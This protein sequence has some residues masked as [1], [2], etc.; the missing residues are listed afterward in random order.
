MG[1]S[2]RHGRWLMGWLLLTGCEPAPQ[3]ARHTVEEYRVARDLRES[4]LRSCAD[5][6]GTLRDTPDCVNAQRAAT[7]ESRGSLRA[8]DPVGLEPASRPGP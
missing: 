1:S 7:L 4:M 5:D 6:P 8:S 2:A 3:V